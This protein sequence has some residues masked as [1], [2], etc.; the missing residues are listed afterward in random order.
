MNKKNF[1][2]SY[3]KE[4]KFLLDFDED[5]FEKIISLSDLLIES[6]SQK[7]L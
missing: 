2:T 5:L 6:N 3:F 4:I 1:L 7:K